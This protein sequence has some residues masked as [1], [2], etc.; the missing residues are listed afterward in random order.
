MEAALDRYWSM[1]LDFVDALGE[2]R[3]RGIPL[4]LVGNFCKYV[5]RPDS[6]IPAGRPDF[7]TAE[8][9]AGCFRK[10]IR[11]IQ[12]AFDSRISQLLRPAPAR[13][14]GTRVVLC[15][16]LLRFPDS[17]YFEYF[18]PEKAAIVADFRAR[19]SGG[20]RCG[21]PVHN[22]RE[23]ARDCTKWVNLIVSAAEQL[24]NRQPQPPILADP[25]L[26]ERFLADLPEMVHLIDRTDRYM[27]ADPPACVVVG[28]TELMITR[29]LALVARRRGIPVIC[30]QHGLIALEESYMP[31]F[32][33]V[34]AVYGPADLDWYAE[35][36]VDRCRLAVTGH[37][38]YDPIFT[39][40]GMPEAVFTKKF[41]V[42]PNERRV[43]VATQPH[44]PV[45]Q[46][47]RIVRSLEGYR[48]LRV[49]LKPHPLEEKSGKTE[50]YARLAGRFGNVTL[51]STRSAL[52]EV[53]ANSHCV[54]V[55]S[56]TVGLEA[57][58]FG[59]PLLVLK[60]PT[61]GM[62]EQWG[63]PAGTPE[64]VARL[65]ADVVLSERNGSQGAGFEAGRLL[66]KIY[67]N[68]L[69]APLLAKLIRRTSGVD[70]RPRISWLSDGM[71]LKG[72][73]PAIYLFRQGMRRRIAGPKQLRRLI[74]KGNGKSNGVKVIKVRPDLMKRIPQGE[75]IR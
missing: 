42:P 14:K 34:Q 53:L 56:S 38:R 28:T 12:P 40:F 21:L 60:G 36:G 8:A 46:I 16:S 23:Y 31:V 5:G 66:K 30:L 64:E 7:D 32:A 44:L 52:Y 47:E 37:P 75:P 70:C 20:F 39:E 11:P 50:S 68:K 62:F 10:P 63:V 4:A 22:L 55:E 41:G 15:T 24:M 61:S 35:R 33:D 51:L 73:G 69:S 54:I 71:L 43:L 13:T 48:G 65:S 18:R 9:E 3:F 59:R 17:T 74:N 26:R 6:A 27:A 25:L 67:P 49:L 19:G 72:D 2:F 57:L 1:C 29:V 45:E 58:L